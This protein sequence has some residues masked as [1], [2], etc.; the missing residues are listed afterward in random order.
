MIYYVTPDVQVSEYPS[1][2][3][4]PTVEVLALPCELPTTLQSI[5]QNMPADVGRYTNLV[6]PTLD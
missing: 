1:L 2:G 6:G 4:L 3:E 5:R